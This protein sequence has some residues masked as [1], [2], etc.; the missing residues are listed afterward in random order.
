VKNRVSGLLI[1]VRCVIDKGSFG[2]LK[3]LRHATASLDN[4]SLGW[5][6]ILLIAD[7][8]TD[9]SGFHGSRIGLF[10]LIPQTAGHG[11]ASL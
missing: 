5:I 4:R 3:A 7:V 9:L 2:L 10:L 1:A 8:P 6:Q 11:F